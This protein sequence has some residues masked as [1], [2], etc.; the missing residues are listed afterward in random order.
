MTK[1]KNFKKS[2][3]QM[4]VSFYQNPKYKEVI[5]FK[6]GGKSRLIK[7]NKAGDSVHNPNAK[8]RPVLDNGFISTNNLLKKPK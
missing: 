6:C 8:T 7:K 3:N 1:L 2:F 4:I 5:Q